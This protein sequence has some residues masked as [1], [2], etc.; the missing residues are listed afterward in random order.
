MGLSID[1][2]VRIAHQKSA[3]RRC[4]RHLC[5]VSTAPRRPGQGHI[6]GVVGGGMDF[7]GGDDD[8]DDGSLDAFLAAGGGGGDSG[9]GFGAGLDDDIMAAVRTARP[10]TRGRR[11]CLFF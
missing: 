11:C 8:D 4:H 9:A 3:T 7:G 5:L 6:C 1:V 2:F 10:I